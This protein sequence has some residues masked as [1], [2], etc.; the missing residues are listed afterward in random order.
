MDLQHGALAAL[1]SV[2]VPRGRK[3][4]RK[5]VMGAGRGELLSPRRGGI[6]GNFQT[7]SCRVKKSI[8]GRKGGVNI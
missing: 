2:S 7:V 6:G 4:V 8:P 5:A 1:L 3:G